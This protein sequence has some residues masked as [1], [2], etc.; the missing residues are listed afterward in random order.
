MNDIKQRFEKALD[1][2]AE[3]EKILLL[4][5]QQSFDIQIKSDQSPV[6]IADKK[7]EEK[8][9]EIILRHFPNDG[10]I[11]EEFPRI[12]GKSGY[13]WTIDPIDGTISFVHGSPLFGSMIGLFHQD[14]SQMGLINFPALKEIVYAI[15]GE[16][17]YW[18]SSADKGFKRCHVGNISELKNATF[19]YSDINYFKEKNRIDVFQTL[20]NQSKY[21]RSW[22]DAYGHMLVATGRAHIMIDP[23][24]VKIWDVTPLKIVI[25]E[26]GGIF[27]SINEAANIH[28]KSALSFS[29]EALAN[30]VT[31]LFIPIIKS[32]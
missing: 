15:K 30:Q 25:E 2:M 26:A 8:I 9:R 31:K 11:G 5:Y 21:A 18:K 7:A 20:Q 13:T 28:C 17:S 32:K 23:D 10:I 29:T 1:M 16:G 4:Y 3:A 6:T 12:E 22:G 19:C 24:V 27:H 14:V